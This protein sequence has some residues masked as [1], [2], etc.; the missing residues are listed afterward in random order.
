MATRK[1]ALMIDDDLVAQARQILGTKTTTETISEALLEVIRVQG[2]ARGLERLREVGLRVG[3]ALE[4]QLGCTEMRQRTEYE[5]RMY[6]AL[7]IKVKVVELTA[8]RALEAMEQGNFQMDTGTGWAM[9]YP[10]PED[11]FM[12][13]YSKNFPREGANYCRYSRPEFDR[14]YEQMA[15]MDDGPERIAT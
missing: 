7:G 10:D 4:R 2:R 1:T 8:A 9:D 3:E 13:F 6:E 5:Q 14:A 11:F 15:T 12:V